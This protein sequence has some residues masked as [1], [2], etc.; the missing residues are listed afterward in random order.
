MAKLISRVTAFVIG[1]I[2]LVGLAFG[3]TQLVADTSGDC[4]GYHGTCASQMECEAL[5]FMLF[6]ENQGLGN[7]EPNGC[8][9]CAEF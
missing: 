8:C 4:Q 1:L 5:C 9:L 3:A 6:P 2:V 7:C